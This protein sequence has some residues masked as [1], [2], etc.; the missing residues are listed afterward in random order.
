MEENHENDTTRR[1]FLQASALSVLAAGQVTAC[2]DRRFPEPTEHQRSFKRSRR[3]RVYLAG[4]TGY[5]SVS[6]VMAVAWAQVAP[7]VRD[8][9]VFLKVNLI[10]YREGKPVCTDAAVVEACVRLLKDSGAR[11]IQVGDGPGI[12]RD[13]EEVARLSGIAEVCKKHGLELVDLNIDDLEKVENPLKFTGVD[14]FLV[15]RS[16]VR[17]DLVISVPKLKTHH[18]ALLTCAMKNLF[19]VIPGRKYGWPKNILHVRGIDR[20][21]VDL[22][23]VVKP[24]FAVVDGVTAMQGDGPL[25]GTERDMQILVLGDDLVAVD[26]VC[27]MCM[28]LPVDKIPYLNLAGMV[29]GHNDLS[30]VDLL[31][32]SIAAVK[33]KFILP[34]TFE[35]DGTPKNFAGLSKGADTGVT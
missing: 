1:S 34:P 21:I 22:V 7:P 30:Q 35:E 29:L 15:P 12:S 32:K 26:T 16:I 5:E 10:D 33:Q 6:E 8:K 27:A 13:T 3:S 9:S 11:S 14:E 18:W 2:G 20:S 23:A 25:N 4:T 17:T 28:E 24:G 31:G 19:G